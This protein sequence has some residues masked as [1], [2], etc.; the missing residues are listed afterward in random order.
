MSILMIG[1]DKVGSIKNMLADYGVEE[2][3]HWDGRNKSSIT[4]KEVPERTECIVMLT[5]YLNHNAMK[6]FKNLAKKRNIPL[7]C[8][9]RSV[10]S[11]YCEFCKRFGTPDCPTDAC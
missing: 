5:S 6:Y 4:R 3:I 11:V 10:T 2:V 1:G 8:T 7:I 9:E